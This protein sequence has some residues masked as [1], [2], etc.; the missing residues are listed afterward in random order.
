MKERKSTFS[1]RRIYM[2]L[3]FFAVLTTSV[4][5]QDLPAI[6]STY[7][8]KNAN[9]IQGPGRKIEMGTLVIKDGVI[10][11]VGKNVEVPATA[12][13]V[14]ADSMYIYAG[15][16][17]GLSHTGQE[18]PKEV[19]GG[20]GRSDVKDPGNPPNDIAG[21]DPERRASDL[22]NASDKSV[23]DMRELGFTAANVVPHGRMLPG[24]G[25]LVLLTGESADEML[26]KE[27]TVLFSQLDGAPGVY[28]ST[29]M[30]V[31]AKYRE[32]YRQAEQA[33]AYEAKYKNKASGMS[34]P[35]TSRVLQA[36][37]PVLEKQQRVAFKAEDVLDIER[38]LI[39]KKD[40]GFNL[41]LSEVKQGWDLTDKIKASGAEVLLSLNLPE[42]EE[43]KTDSTMTDSTSVEK[44][45]KTAVDI[46]REEL[47]ARKK[48]MILNYYTQPALFKSKGIE[49]GFSTLGVKSSDVK[50]VLIK[51]IENGLTED[52]A[53][54]ALTTAPAQILGVSSIMGTLDEGKMAN[55]FITDKPYFDKEANV[56]Y[57][58]V[59]GQMHNLK[60]KPGK[61]GNGEKAVDIKG[62]WSYSS[63]TP[64]G[65]VNGVITFKGEPGDY[66]GSISNSSTDDSTDF[67]DITV[68]GNSVVFEFSIVSDGETL[69]ITI[70][71]NIEGET[72]EGTMT[73]GE[74]GSFPIKGDK[75]PEEN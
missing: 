65:V 25:A 48:Q 19:P 3:L 60:D 55:F 69:K 36:F 47:E 18:E 74:Y 21:I 34:R 2:L 42:M 28:P 24:Q 4:Y 26:Y 38:V 70:T 13:V 8:I 22:L 54:A 72:F 23:N 17:E 27:N 67:N 64:Q 7:V 20:R 40:L 75:M 63:E 41:I 49:F 50:D 14:E 51:F 62:K 43:E 68:D 45:E 31:M 53:L 39:L 73:A 5:G 6:T 66:S 10:T 46:E 35:N 11:A 37:Y 61:K 56:K 71:M 9:I 57:T 12:Q 32:L 30:A 58:F 59:D 52:Q 33:K 44:K 29:V 1:Q 16:I 15:F